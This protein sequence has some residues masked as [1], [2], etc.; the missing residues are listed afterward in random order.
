MT[1]GIDRRGSVKVVG[2]AIAHEFERGCKRGRVTWRFGDA[3]GRLP[4]SLQQVT[5]GADER[6]A[7]TGRVLRIRLQRVVKRHEP[8]DDVLVGHRIRREIP[9]SIEP[10][11]LQQVAEGRLGQ[12][13]RPIA[14]ARAAGH[15][16]RMRL[17][18]IEDE[19]RARMGDVRA[20]TAPELRTAELRDRDDEG[21]VHMRRVVVRREIG[22][23]QIHAR[24]AGRMP[25][26]RGVARVQTRHGTSSDS[27]SAQR[28]QAGWTARTQSA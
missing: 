16:A 23:Q 3:L 24:Q 13:E 28:S 27:A 4:V 14:P 8:R 7:M 19:Q 25:V 10:D 6:L 17:G 5:E 18:R 9:R 12:I 15:A 21:V 2:I 20:A 22:L 26:A 11:G 1:M